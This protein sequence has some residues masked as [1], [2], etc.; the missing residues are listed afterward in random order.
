M[1][2]CIR[3]LGLECRSAAHVAF[4][5]KSIGSGSS[6]ASTQLESPEVAVKAEDSQPKIEPTIMPQETRPA[7]LDSATEVGGQDKTSKDITGQMT[8]PPKDTT[9][10][11]SINTTDTISTPNATA[12]ELTPAQQRLRDI[13]L[14]A[15]QSAE[16][17]EAI[18]RV[19]KL[20]W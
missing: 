18:C 13:K 17:P 10:V 8:Q 20:P 7:A 3:L 5:L 2:A 4:V 6:N 12:S 15:M 14:K 1:L 19:L 16:T 9:D 11:P